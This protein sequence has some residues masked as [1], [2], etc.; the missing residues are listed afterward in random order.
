MKITRLNLLLIL[1]LIMN[2]TSFAS[3]IDIKT[4]K[5]KAIAFLQARENR[6]YSAND[7]HLDY[8]TSSVYLFSNE[9][10]FALISA[11]DTLPDLLGYGTK[12]KGTLPP[13]LQ[14]Y[15]Q[16]QKSHPLSQIR[17]K[18]KKTGPLLTFVRHQKSPY[19]NYCP[20]YKNEQ[21]EITQRHCLVGCVATALEEVIS[22]YRRNVVLLDTLHG[23][24]TSQYTIDDILPGTSVNCQLI[25]D[26]Y[27]V[28]DYTKEEEDAV[29]RLSY[30]CG[31]AA[32][33][34]W[35]IS[36]S[37]ANVRNLV[38]PM[39]RA[40]GYQYVKFVDSY[41]YAPLDWLEM[42][43]NEIYAQRPILYAAFN[44]WVGGHAFVIDGIDEEGFFHVNWGYAGSYDGYF[45]LDVLNYNE[46][47]KE[48]TPEGMEAGFFCNHQALLLCPDYVKVNLP[49]TIA[50]T[51][52][53]LVIDSMTIDMIPETEKHSPMTVYIRNT[54][55]QPLTTPFE[56]FTNLPNDTALFEQADYVAL[57][58]TILAP[59]E[60]RKMVIHANFNKD[61]ERILR[62]SPDGSNIIYEKAINIKKGT[63]P[64]LTFHEPDI[65]YLEKDRVLVTL[66]VSNAEGVGRCGQELLYEIGPGN[67]DTM[68]D[69]V[70]HSRHL[71]VLPGETVCDTVSF[72]YLTPGKTYTLLIRS[73][74]KVKA[75][76]TFTMPMSSGIENLTE[77]KEK[78]RWFLPDGREIKRPRSKGLYL[79]LRGKQMNKIYIK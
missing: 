73:P 2:T 45:R 16:V 48:M 42:M 38:D 20:L 79:R 7:L 74:W 23:W 11:D 27:D 77:T 78:E 57:C 75:Q 28:D 70:R 41:Q 53:E 52:R 21:G 14:Q 62:I 17:E 63:E 59:F 72:K 39:Q 47:P 22:Y 12:N 43:R 51:G 6:T 68:K 9:T 56:F 10:Q 69:G 64:R 49:D 65:T 5:A 50:R 54:S 66:K 36:A 37:G 60:Q 3:P 44:M 33:M 35:G 32:H 26:N 4:A 8:V 67:A 13:A 18:F 34:N 61:G 76:K 1:L 55:N 71:Y 30:Y 40:F 25:R 24:E 15:M 29:A 19:N 58:G 31:V 46:P